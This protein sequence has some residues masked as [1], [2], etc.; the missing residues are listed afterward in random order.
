MLAQTRTT[1]RFDHS[2]GGFHLRPRPTWPNPNDSIGIHLQ[3][4]GRW[5]CW[6]ILANS[7]A[8][9]YFDDDLR[10][11]IEC[12]LEARLAENESA[13]V[14]AWCCE[15]WMVG[16]ANQTACPT[17]VFCHGFDANLRRKART[18]IKEHV[19]HP[20]T[21][22]K[23]LNRGCPI[24]CGASSTSGLCSSFVFRN[25]ASQRACGARIEVQ[26]S[27]GE[28]NELHAATLGGLI[29][30]NDTIYGLTVNHAFEKYSEHVSGLFDPRTRVFFDEEDEEE[31]VVQTAFQG[32][33]QIF[34][35][36]DYILNYN[37]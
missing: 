29:F 25:A 16:K 9:V 20:G 2:F 13:P 19:T 31:A 18:I 8:A 35:L 23:S 3:N 30:V 26:P 12:D 5:Q 14:D 32:K 27:R 6:S 22:V 34:K 37:K 7:A 1:E 21:R 11:K 15:Y 36:H 4:Y 28:K 17:A 33:H 24:L 10:T